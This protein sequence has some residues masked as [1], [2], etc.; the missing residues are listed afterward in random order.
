MDRSARFRFALFAVAALVPLMGLWWLSV[1][2]MIAA[3]RPL[4]AWFAALLLPVRDL[5]PDGAGG[6]T[7]QTS[8]QVTSGKWADARQEANFPVAAELLRRYLVAWP[9]FL[10][11]ALAPP[12]APRLGLML[13]AGSAAL[14]LLFV[15][16]ATALLF[17]FVAVL[18]NHAPNPADRL[19]FVP[20]PFYVAA[21]HYSG[22]IFF[23]AGLAFYMASYVLPLLAPILLWFA[24]N[25]ASRRFGLG[26]PPPC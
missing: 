17:V 10:A 12:R 1:D 2:S 24:F 25:P 11:L 16:S 3:L 26:A 18:I 4:V 14:T 8:L 9:F 5:L 21:P 7:A 6:W 13:V 20:P 23:L 15:L 19:Q 22:P